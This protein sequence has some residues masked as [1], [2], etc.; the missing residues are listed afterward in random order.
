LYLFLP[1]KEEKDI[2]VSVFWFLKRESKNSGY[3]KVSG[4]G[5]IEIIASEIKIEPKDPKDVAHT[6]ALFP[7]NVFWGAI[8]NVG[9]IKIHIFL[10]NG[11]INAPKTDH[12]P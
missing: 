12:F 6:H 11:A 10:G 1:S 2:Y 9:S 5:G 3:S 7:I 8:N 4:I